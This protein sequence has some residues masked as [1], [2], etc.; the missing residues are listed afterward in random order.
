[1]LVEAESTGCLDDAIDLVS[2]L[3]N[4]RPLFAR[5]PRPQDPADDLRSCGCD[6]T[7]TIRAVR[8]GDPLAHG[9][10]RVALD[11][12][13]RVRARLRAMYGLDARSVGPFEVDRARLARTA[14][15]AD[16]RCVH[17][18]RKRGNEVAFSNGGTEIEL[19]RD[20]AVRGAEGLEAIAVLATRAFG[21]G[22]ETTV[23]VTCATP[24]PLP[25]LVAAGLG[26]DRL[27]AVTVDHGRVLATVERVYARKVIEQREET[28]V[29]AV[30]R[31]AIGELFVRGSVLKGSLPEAKQ[32]LAAWALATQLRATGYAFDD[33]SW[34][35]LEAEQRELAAWVAAR[36]EALGVETGEDLALLSPG[37]L[38]PPE[39]PYA[40]KAQI[41]K[42]YPLAVTVGDARYEVDYDVPA[43][44][45]TLRMV[46]GIR[47]DP[48]PLGYLPKFTGM[49]I[50]VEAGR[51]LWVLRERG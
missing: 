31:A 3:A 4:G 8:G 25:W 49:K 47:K 21:D 38:L 11:E 19:G 16:P 40:A 2:V 13:R 46:K 34:A 36:L 30:A 15:A 29:G 28:P 24:L 6:A 48:P 37:D 10:D 43:R 51:S 1:M 50:I 12:A 18:A 41:E 42:E 26:R 39:L 33:D 35:P 7:A 20:S 9:L 23:E 44:T 32:R 27:G 22:R 45:A 17:V 5:G 14:L